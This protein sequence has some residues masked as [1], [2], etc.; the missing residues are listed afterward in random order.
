MTTHSGFT[1]ILIL[2]GLLTGM[3]TCATAARAQHPGGP[4]G[5]F[6]AVGLPDKGQKQLTVR[7]PHG[8]DAGGLAQPDGA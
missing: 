3:L 5:I 2:I 4:L 8:A 1:R 7:L 6:G